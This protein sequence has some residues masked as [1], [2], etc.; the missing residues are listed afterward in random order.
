[1]IYTFTRDQKKKTWQILNG[2][3]LK[4]VM[5]YEIVMGSSY[6]PALLIPSLSG[7]MASVF[8]P[9]KGLANVASV[10]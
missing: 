1:M 4:H 2:P 9:S 7:G 8:Y 3:T 5:F 6:N 10:V